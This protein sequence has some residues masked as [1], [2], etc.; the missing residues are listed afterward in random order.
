MLHIPLFTRFYTSQVVQDFFHQQY[1]I[2]IAARRSPVVLIPVALGRPAALVV[3][4]GV[5]GS[6]K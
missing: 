1:Q 2:L 3:E 4:V 6:R 5:G